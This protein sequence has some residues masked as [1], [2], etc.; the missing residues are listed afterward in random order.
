MSNDQSDMPDAANRLELALED[1]ECVHLWLDDLGAARESGDNE[2]SI[3]G[4]IGLVTVRRSLVDELARIA[5]MAKLHIH[6]FG[7]EEIKAKIDEAI[8]AI[9]GKQ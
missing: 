2:Y 4:R 7:A 8:A 3:I 9:K 5:N 1:I 6:G